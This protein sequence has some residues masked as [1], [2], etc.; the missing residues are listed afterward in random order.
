MLNLELVATTPERES[1]LQ[2]LTV[3]LWMCSSSS[4]KQPVRSWSSSRKVLQTRH[5][6]S[7]ASIWYLGTS[8]SWL[9]WAV[10]VF[11]QD[12]GYRSIRATEM[13]GMEQLPFKEELKRLQIFKE[14]ITLTIWLR[15][16]RAWRSGEVEYRVFFYQIVELDVFNQ[17]RFKT[18]KGS[19]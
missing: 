14:R 2:W 17:T 6:D 3:V 8:T 16:T 19:L 7:L 11:T 10:L 9:L 4:Q 13:M 15:L 18:E 5:R 12:K 1:S